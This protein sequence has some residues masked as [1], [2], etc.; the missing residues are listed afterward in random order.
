MTTAD[1][2]VIGGGVNGASTAYY[3]AKLGAGKIVL[4][5]RGTLAS[6]ATGKSGAL[7]RMHYTNPHESKLAYESLK[8]FRNWADEVGGDCGW[9]NP[10][11]VQIVG[12][13]Y[14][15]NLAA[16]VADQQAIGINTRIVDHE[17]L[18]VLFPGM[19]VDDIGAAA[20][21]ADSG[22]ADP[23]QT[24]FAFAEVA[25]RLGVEIRTG[26]EATRINSEHGRVTGVE[27]SGGPIH[28][29]TVVM[30][31]GV[32]TNA[33]LEGL[34]LDFGL[35]PNRSAVAIFRWPETFQGPLPVVIDAINDAWL[36]PE[37]PVTALIG[38]ESAS[39]PGS[40]DS[41]DE[42]ISSEVVESA[43]ATLAKRFPAFENALMRG[44]WAG[45]YM[46]S[47]DH[48]PIIDQIPS[49]G[50]LYCMIGDSGSS[51]KTGPAVGKCLAEWIVIG[52]PQTADL[53]PF[54][55]TRFAEGKP[56]TDESSNYGRRRRT[57]SR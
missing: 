13:G 2:V 49:I 19:Y 16:N 10:G 3:L 56:W 34:G 32:R 29:D 8:V 42:T 21:E 55:S 11:F 52:E 30:A 50:G 25:R 47:P 46:M 14:E 57:I 41:F 28:S 20:Y 40:V 7:V 24:T 27:T 38:A 1:V 39:Y 12:E 54:R 22:W 6:G 35:T 44:G 43:R 5:E 9:Q 36:R 31:T 37:S 48:R 15:G 23:N 17:E 18:Q 4:L 33:L 26:C 51:F 45:M 53:A